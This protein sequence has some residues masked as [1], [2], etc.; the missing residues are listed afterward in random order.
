MF[1]RQSVNAALLMWGC[2][3]CVIAVLCMAINYN[4]NKSKKKR[5]IFMQISCALL[6][7][8]DVFA[9]IFRGDISAAG[10]LGVRISNFIVFLMSDAILMMFHSYVCCN[11]FENKEK[12]SMPGIRVRMV[13]VLC[14]I[15]IILVI[16]SQ[17]TNLY[18]Y[19]DADNIYHRNNAYIVSVLIPFIGMVIDLWLLLEYRASLTGEMLVAMLSYIVLPVTAMVI[20]FFCY[21][22][23][24]IN[25]AIAGSAI[26]M[27]IAAMNDQNK[28][29]LAREKESA[30]LKISLLISQ[31]APHF[32]YNTL[33][34]IRTLCVKNPVQA[35]ELIDDFAGYLRGNLNSLN[36]EKIPFKQELEYVKHY[37]S[38]EEVRFGDR[39]QAEYDIREENFIVPVLAIQIMVENAVKH[40]LYPKEE[41]EGIVRIES[42]KE[43]EDIVVTVKD[44]G[45]GFDLEKVKDEEEA[46]IGIKNTQERIERLCGGNVTINSIIGKGTE[47]VIRFP[48]EGNKIKKSNSRVAEN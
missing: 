19:I 37:L 35:Q 4:F 32:I 27:F 48:I 41:G 10:Y 44:N 14:V 12:D 24:F 5:I 40:G 23:S 15:G 2:L 17:F 26:I 36:K 46:H 11:L 42:V 39:V 45:V 6:L 29:M 43:A 30:E 21:G 38:I 22:V 31:I 33:A 20:Q 9:W 3:F 25:F 8:S 47:V 7:L 28:A 13:Y 34:S 18:Y 16:V 1:S